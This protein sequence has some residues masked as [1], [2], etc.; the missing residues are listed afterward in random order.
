MSWICLDP[1]SASEI[2]SYRVSV[3]ETQHR[4]QITFSLVTKKCLTL[5]LNEILLAVSVQYFCILPNYIFAIFSN[6]Y[7]VVHV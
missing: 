1:S 2:S 3:D 4:L 6:L 5:E 7:I